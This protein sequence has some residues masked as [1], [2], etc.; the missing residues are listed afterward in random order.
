MTNHIII[1]N[2][3]AWRDLRTWLQGMLAVACLVLAYGITDAND[4]AYQAQLAASIYARHAERLQRELDQPAIRIDADD[5]ARFH[6]TAWKVRDP[7]I[8]QAAQRCEQL[9]QFLTMARTH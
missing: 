2:R 5:P 9:G 8:G 4:R 6:C 1:E 3:P 7:W